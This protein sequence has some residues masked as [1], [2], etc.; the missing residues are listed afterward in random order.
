M[1]FPKSIL[2]YSSLLSV[3]III[4]ACG[5]KDEAE[6][7]GVKQT[8]V[9][10]K[11]NGEE[12]SIHQINFQLSRMGQLNE[13]QGKEAAK[14]TLVRLVDETLLKQKAL[15]A[16]L[17]RDPKVLQAMESTKNQILAQAYLEQEMVNASKPSEKEI[18]QFYSE[19]P[20]L[21]ENRRVFR[22]Q[23]LAVEV[24]KEKLPEIQEA[25]T[26]QKNIN[27]MAQWLT[28]KSY[29]F[30]ANSNV[31]NAEQLPLPLL[32]KLQLLKDGEAIAV[33]TGK[34]VNIIYVASS[35]TQ[36]VDKQ[37]A[38]PYIEK[39]FLNINKNRLIAAEM[40][41]IKEAAKVEYVGAFA[42]MKKNS[43]AVEA[44]PSASVAFPKG[45]SQPTSAAP[46][47]N[48]DSASKQQS[49]DKGLSGL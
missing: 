29:K 19:H 26:E 21:F 13:T 33:D 22:L 3:V 31:R 28:S 1:Y 38:K 45:P 7:N 6:T 11:V 34:S 23:E 20:D 10:A 41:K 44:A 36:S 25:L 12:I 2:I 5:N 27:N 49:M 9:V 24:S 30:A 8:Q 46:A 14:Q 16:K 47:A 4:T 18:D 15:E 37:K 43:P 48:A 32:A 40:K 17:D 39:Y 35:Q 42:D